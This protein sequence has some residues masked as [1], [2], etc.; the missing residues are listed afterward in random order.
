MS[1]NCSHDC[2][3][4][5]EECSER[6]KTSL[7]EKPH[8]LSNIKKVIGIVSGKGGVGKSLVTSMLAVLM[9]RNGLK[10]AI[11]DADI[12]GPSIPKSFG[13]KKKAEGSDMGLFP[14]KSKTGIEVMSLNLLLENET[15]PVVWRGPIIAGTVK[16]FW[17]DVIWGDIDY[18]FID[19]PPGTGDVSLT[20]FQSIPV[21]G[22]IIVTSPQEL[23][24]MIVTKAVNMAKMMNIPILGLVENMSFVKCPDC[25]K[26]IKVF[27]ESHINDIAEKYNIKSVARLPID[28]AI[29]KACDSGLIELFEGDWLNNMTES[30][31]NTEIR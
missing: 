6:E 28:P 17:T 22:I 11:L 23:V 25:G 16:Q 12:T 9:N 7:L 10:T 3:S 1:E 18:M 15:D 13:L 30:I 14:V 19:M 4:C 24:S 20:V 27:G 5:G 21:D 29:A 2:G 26:E 8:E 31:E